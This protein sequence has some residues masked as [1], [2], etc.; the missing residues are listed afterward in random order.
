VIFAK[1]AGLLGVWM[2]R[3]ARQSELLIAAVLSA[4]ALS[5]LEVRASGSASSASLPAAPSSPPSTFVPQL[6]PPVPGRAAEAPAVLGVPANIS[7]SPAAQRGTSSG[8]STAAAPAAV[9]SKVPTISSHAEQAAL[10]LGVLQNLKPV[11]WTPADTLVYSAPIAVVP[12]AGP[13]DM[14]AS[15]LQDPASTQQ[16]TAA[17]S[18][19]SIDRLSSEMDAQKVAMLQEFGCTSVFSRSFQRGQRRLNVRIFQFGSSEGAFGAYSLLRQ[20]ATTVV[21]RGDASSEDEQSISFWQGHCFISVS[22]TSQDDEESKNLVRE[23]ADKVSAVMREHSPLPAILQRLPQFERVRASER[24]VMGPQS[25]RRFFPAPYLQSVDF[26]RSRGAAIADYQIQ[27]PPDRLKLLLIEYPT[28]QA[29]L[30][31]YYRY[32]GNFEEHTVEVA[33]PLGGAASV[34]RVNKNFLL[35]QTRGSDLVI[36]TGA[37]KRESAMF[38]A[39]YMF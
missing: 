20:G 2:K 34:Y 28:P 37:R 26:S 10:V 33:A 13:H 5:C 35:C 6:P 39:R 14:V 21:Q 32:T 15:L 23:I 9:G 24:I 11:G 19:L 38:L 1:L 29:A 36:I 16:P 8:L 22:G 27:A 7:V 4:T 25:T 18:G 12:S 3:S 30:T 17:Q 31:A